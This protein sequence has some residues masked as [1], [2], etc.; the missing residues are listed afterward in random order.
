M[1]CVGR[2]LALA[3]EGL[4]DGNERP[5]GEKEATEAGENDTEETAQ[6]EQQG[7]RML[8]LHFAGRGAS[9]LDNIRSRAGAGHE[10]D[11]ALGMRLV[12]DGSDVGS[13]RLCNLMHRRLE[14][15]G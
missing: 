4:T 8:G 11:D 6:D 15:R 7:E 9:D 13:P 10:G 2:E 3:R 14:R 12:G 1:R 5:A